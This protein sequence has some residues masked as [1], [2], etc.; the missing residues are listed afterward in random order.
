MSGRTHSRVARKLTGLLGADQMSMGVFIMVLCAAVMHATW[1]AVVK[2]DRDRA[3]LLRVIF[4]T[5]FVFSLCLVPFVPLP[6]RESWP[7]LATSALLGVGYMVFLNR[8]YR[9]GDLSHVYP[10]ARGIAPLIVAVV[11]TACLGEQ[12]SH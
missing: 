6:A 3:A 8:A 7:Y 9:V 5:Q 11:A 1:N 4:A 2:S 10:F 12:I